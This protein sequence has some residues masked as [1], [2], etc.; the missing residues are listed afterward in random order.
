MGAAREET[1]NMINF[2]KFNVGPEFANVSGVVDVVVD[3]GYLGVHKFYT[4]ISM[5]IKR[6]MR[7]FTENDIP[8]FILTHWTKTS[9]P[10]GT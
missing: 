6:K 3:Q 8:P 10:S 9:R 1:H 2:A 7:E 5:V 4:S